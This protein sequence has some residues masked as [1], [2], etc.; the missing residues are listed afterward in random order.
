MTSPLTELGRPE[1]HLMEQDVSSVNLLERN[2]R[3]DTALSGER[4]LGQEA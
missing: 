1:D 3:L 4:R 2:H